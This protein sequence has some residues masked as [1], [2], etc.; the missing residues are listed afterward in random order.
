MPKK[1]STGLQRFI[2][3]A[4]GVPLTQT[5]FPGALPHS[6]DR[7]CL[8]KLH[9]LHDGKYT[10]HTVSFKADG[11]RVL[12]GF[13]SERDHQPVA[14]LVDRRNQYTIITLDGASGMYEGTLFDAEFFPESNRLLIFDTMMVCG[15]VCHAEFY[16]NRLELARATLQTLDAIR[17][18]VT[19]VAATYEYPSR[20]P[21]LE[22]A[23]DDW[24]IGVKAIFYASRLA[25]VPCKWRFVDDGLVWT[26]AAAP[27]GTPA[28]KW[29][30][31]ASISIDCTIMSTASAKLDC[32][33]GPTTP[34]RFY[35]LPQALVITEKSRAVWF[36]TTRD[37]V[38]DGPG[39][40][41]CF[42]EGD[43]WRI[44]RF[45]P[46]KEHPNSVATVTA[47]LHNIDEAV[48]REEIH[49]LISK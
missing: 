49:R 45:R 34:Y 29:K 3:K 2:N 23:V 5:T 16:P 31:P 36:S 41:E 11:E 14:F 10:E 15:N 24:T 20:F 1:L 21:N 33:W 12:L 42:W 6:V 39:V 28:F 47:T 26:P 40:Y 32:Q 48:T 7:A 38:T 13:F 18:T 46:D 37:E 22:Y 17:T 43:R 25:A 44:G 27:Y 4:C 35:N 19:H 30:P 9:T 8:A